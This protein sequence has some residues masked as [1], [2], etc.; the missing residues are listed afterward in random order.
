MKPRGT[1]AGRPRYR[2]ILALTTHR[3][4]VRV[5]RL[6]RAEVVGGI[7]IIVAAALGILAANSPLSDA[8][9]S[10]RETT[11]GPE[12][13][14]L[15]LSIGAWA[16]DGLLAI[17]FF[18]VGLEL[19]REFVEGALRK[20]STAIVP[21]A[22][23]VGGVVVPALIY[24]AFTAGTPGVRGWAI[25]TATDIAFAVAVL[26]L[27]APRI[28]VALR[29]F[30]LT[31]AV[32]D[33]LI[34][35]GIIAAFY[36]DDV[37]LLPLALSLIPMAIYA[38]LARRYTAQLA[39]SGWAPWLIM[40]PIGI[41]AWGLFHA[42]G[43]HATIAGV[44]LAFLV[45]VRRGGAQL[46]EVFEHRFRPLSTGIA[47]PIFAFFAAGVAVGQVSDFPFHP[48]ALGVMTGLVVGKLVGITFTTWLLTK[49]TRATLDPAVRW[50]EIAGVASLAGIGFT[51]SLLIADLSF[52]DPA[53]GDTARLA[54][55]VASLIAI[56][57]AALFLVRRPRPHHPAQQ[58]AGGTTPTA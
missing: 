45:P 34:A 42:S 29:M 15:N 50:N 41:V 49:F 30:L 17:F 38:F 19:K 18:M 21:V 13:L 48:I 28:P 40:L 22:A 43:I 52:T 7:I 58:L 37:S 36:T 46:A 55:M 24:V 51:V 14:H 11:I 32:V 20:F 6:L 5:N 57:V 47:V 25:P 31:L 10:L 1:Q 35:I 44:V 9:F 2:R 4:A 54:V 27:L 8:Y 56:I 3:E 12:S 39:R 53:D 26:G 16:S 23:A 33:D